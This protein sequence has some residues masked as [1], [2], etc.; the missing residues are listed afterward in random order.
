[1]SDPLIDLRAPL[2]ALGF[3]KRAGQIYTA[4][5]T[6]DVLGWLGLNKATKHQRPGQFEVNPVVGVRHQPLERL[7]A[8]LTGQQLHE[9]KP[10]TVSTPIGYLLPQRKYTSWTINEQP[11][12]AAIQDFGDAVRDY[13]LPWMRSLTELPQLRRAT[14]DRMG[15]QLEYRLPVVLALMGKP[16]EARQ[17]LTAT[18]KLIDGREDAAASDFRQFVARFESRETFAC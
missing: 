2:E 16:A 3:R 8:E 4:E 13:A 11:D 14:E 7:V 5:I 18:V 9:Y 15:Y 12:R 1:V 6:N 10:P 17:T